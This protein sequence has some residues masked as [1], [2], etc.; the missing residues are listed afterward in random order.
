MALFVSGDGKNHQI[1]TFEGTLVDDFRKG[2]KIESSMIVETD[3]GKLILLPQEVRQMLEFL[4]RGVDKLT[5][6]ER[7]Q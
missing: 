1:T 2:G 3:F 7:L 6:M 5:R 4:R